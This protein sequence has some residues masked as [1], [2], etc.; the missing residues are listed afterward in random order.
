MRLNTSSRFWSSSEPLMASTP[1]PLS[2][3]DRAA[4]EL[5]RMAMDWS[6]L[7]RVVGDL[8]AQLTPL[9]D[10]DIKNVIVG[11]ADIRDRLQMAKGLAF[12]RSFDDDW[13]DDVL[14]LLDFVDNDLRPKRNQAI[15]SEWFRGSRLRR[16]S[17]KTKITKPQAF[18]R[19]LETEKTENVKLSELRKLN[20]II[21]DTTFAF[22]PLVFYMMGEDEDLIDPLSSPTI[23]Y[24]Q[25]LRWAGLGNP[26]KRV[27]AA[28]KR[29]PR[30]SRA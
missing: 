30:S 17:L 16:R 13:L 8:I 21:K 19:E 4:L 23:S 3:A 7:E 22:F 26:T 29:Q 14:F 10:G 18:M 5:G 25:Y 15:H 12:I 27:R 28:R 24:K 2:I 1:K 20:S 6:V 9:P 11:N